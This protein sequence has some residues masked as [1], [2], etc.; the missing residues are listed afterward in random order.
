MHTTACPTFGKIGP[1][2]ETTLDIGIEVMSEDTRM[3]LRN[4][5][6]PFPLDLPR[7]HGGKKY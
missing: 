4:A 5:L 1:L 2:T 6:T 7:V 3:L